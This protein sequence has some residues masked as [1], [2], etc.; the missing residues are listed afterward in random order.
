MLRQEE[1]HAGPQKR[2]AKEGECN[3]KEE[4]TAEGI[5]GE[6]GWQG[7]DPVQDTCAH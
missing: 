1:G 4:P 2:D 6:E 7:E 3:E 5:N